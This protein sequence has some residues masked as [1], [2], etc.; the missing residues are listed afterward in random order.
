M[1]HFY[2][3]PDK[4][5]AL[6]PVIPPGSLIA[7]WQASK[8]GAER[9]KRAEDVQR[10][11]MSGPPADKKSPDAALYRQLA[12]ASGPLF[13]ALLLSSAADHKR[14]E[15]QPRGHMAAAVRDWGL[16]PAAFGKNERGDAIDPASLCVHAPSVVAVRLPADLV[17]GAELV[18]T[19]V[20]DKLTGSEG[21]AQLRVSGGR[22]STEKGLRPGAP[23]VVSDNSRARQR[24]E[25]AFH[26][27]RMLFPAAICYT[28][29]VPVDE[30]IT[31]N[32]FYREDDHLGRLMLDPKQ[33]AYLDRLWDELRFVSQD[34]L[35]L[36]DVLAQ[37]LEYAS[38]DAD[39]SVFEPLKKPIHDGA[40]VFRDRL[41][42]TEP[43][44]VQAIIDFAVRAT[45]PAPRSRSA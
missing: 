25:T 38:Q 6:G 24:I 39:P 19:G 3:E 45:A 30:V 40:V 10:L 35:T 4:G 7:K 16:D 23:I 13:G 27:F 17:A 26:E 34:A 22:A 36:V 5:A 21:S 28:K 8:I 2:S 31:L 37:L 9:R 14:G 11:L 15:S 44:Q 20:L 33:Q 18:V 41:R 43:V 42:K 29:I 32:L 12:S 1:W